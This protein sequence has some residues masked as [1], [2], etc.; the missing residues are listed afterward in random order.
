MENPCSGAGKN[1]GK[2]C[3]DS[4]KCPDCYHVV[5]G[6]VLIATITEVEINGRGLYE[7][8]CHGFAMNGTVHRSTYSEAIQVAR[9]MLPVP[10]REYIRI[11]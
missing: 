8:K 2:C 3:S 7:I 5:I 10:C 4:F 1:I 9:L 11:I 6:E